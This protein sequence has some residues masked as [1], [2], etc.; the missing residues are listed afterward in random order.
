VS[1]G[2]V[3]RL[4]IVRRLRAARPAILRRLRNDLAAGAPL[5]QQPVLAEFVAGGVP[6]AKIVEMFAAVFD[7]GVAEMESEAAGGR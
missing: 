7:E 3:D 5:E 2:V 4:E 6:A 1:A